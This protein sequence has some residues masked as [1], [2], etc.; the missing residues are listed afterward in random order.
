MVY[1]QVRQGVDIPGVDHPDTVVGEVRQPAE[2]R[3]AVAGGDE[4]V[5]ARAH[6]HPPRARPAQRHRCQV[7]EDLP[8]RPGRADRDVHHREDLRP[9]PEGVP[10]VGADT[11]LH[12]AGA[13]LLREV[14]HARGGKRRA[15][16]VTE[17][18]VGD[19]YDKPQLGRDL[20]GEQ[21]RLEVVEVDVV[22]GD[23][24]HRAGDRRLAQ[25]VTGVYRVAED[26]YSPPLKAAPQ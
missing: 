25:R 19:P 21:R 13:G 22:A 16:L 11:G 26:G 17:L 24:C 2:Q 10:H 8:E 14:Q 5:A 12:E 23:Q 20:G 18:G 7:A 9:E 1:R 15:E 6:L 3:D 4:R